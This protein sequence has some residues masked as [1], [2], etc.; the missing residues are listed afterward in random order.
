MHVVFTHMMLDHTGTTRV[1]TSAR[2]FVCVSWP[3]CAMTSGGE[4]Q[5][6]RRQL[7][8]LRL[9]GLL[10]SGVKV[11]CVLNGVALLAFHTNYTH[12]HAFQLV[13]S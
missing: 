12:G 3:L 7:A 2:C 9:K 8:A 10:R 1:C 5:H 11:S 6:S 4:V 13:V